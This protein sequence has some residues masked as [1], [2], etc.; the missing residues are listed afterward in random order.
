[1]VEANPRIVPGAPAPA[2]ISKSQKKKRKAVKGKGS[3]EPD[4]HGVVSDT[5][6]S[7]LDTAPSVSD[8][9]EGATTPNL[10][11]ATSVDE[12]LQSAV[13]ED[14]TYKPSPVVDLVHKRLKAIHKKIASITSAHKLTCLCMPYSLPIELHV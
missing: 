6:A 4:N 14:A 3:A 13:E 2:P 7:V 5:T 8:T 11:L 12:T 1:M 10:V 9:K